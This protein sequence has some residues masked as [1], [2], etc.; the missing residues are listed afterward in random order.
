MAG[1]Y[2][3]NY[4]L[5]LGP[6]LALVLAI[7]GPAQALAN[8]PG[9]GTNGANVT[10][11]DNGTTVTIANGI[12][13][14][15]CNKSSGQITTLNYTFNNTGSL[16]TLNLL[17]GNPNGGKLYWENSNNQGLTFT[18]ALIADPANNGGNYAE[19]ILS[20]TTVA[21][22]LMEIHYSLSRGNTGFYVTPIFI[23]RSTD[24][25]FGMGECRDNIY[26][27]S[28]F[29]WMSVDAARNRLMEVSGGSAIGVNGAPVE[30]SLWTNG[31][32]AGQYEDKYK[33]G[34]DF[35]RQRAWGWSSVGTGGKNVGLWNVCGSVEYYNGGPMKRELMEHIG[36][37]ILNMINGGHYGSAGQD[38][39][40][41]AGEVWS[42][43]Y[44]PYLIY[45]N[46]ITNAI[47]ATNQA[48]QALYNDALAQAAAEQAA[49]PYSWFAN[50]NY[51]AATNRGTVTG[52]ISI[53]DTYDPNAS[54]ANLWVGVVQ[55][56][57]TTTATYDFQL[58]VKPYQFWVKTDM[59]GN[60]SIPDV[61]AGGNYTLYAFGAGAP[62]TYQSQA[63]TGGN[64]PNTVSIPASPFSVTVTVGTTNNLGTVTW[65]PARVA[66]T[67]FE[68]GYP[69]RTGAKFRHGEDWW[70]GDLGPSAAYPSPIW[71]KW[72]ELS[73]DYP[74]G[75]NYT[76]G[77]S[78][79]TTDWNFVQPVVT[80]DAGN[81]NGSSSTITF[82]LPTAPSG[83]ASF[84]LALSSD[85]QG[86]L[87]I[88]VNGGN[89]AG[90]TGYFPNYSSSSSGSDV[91]IRESDHGVFSDT[92]INF[93]ATL[94]H[95]GQNTIT[96]NMRK[97]G[98]F[99]NHAMYD[100][101]RLEVPNY[102]PPPPASSVAYPGN[103]CALVCWP[104]TPGATSYNIL[105]ST[106]TGTG[107]V[108]I[109]NGVVGPVCG[110][111]WNNATY[112]DAT[113]ANGTT[114]YYVVR[115]VNPV[116]SST[117]SPQSSATPSAALSTSA[118]AVP[119][120]LSIG[121]ATHQSVTLNWAAAA[122]A[123]FY[124]IYRS[125]L[126]NNGG[127]ASNILATLVL[128]NNVIG[129][130]YTDTSSTDGS[131]Y[132][133]S[134]T[135][136]SAGGT[137]AL[138]TAAIAKPLPNAPATAPGSLLATPSASTNISLDWSGVSGAVGY[139]I[140]RATSVNG[141]YL[142]LASITETTYTDYGV[143]TNSTYFYKITA[144]NAGGVSTAAITTTKPPTPTGLTAV[145]GNTKVVLKW[146]GSI[147]ATNYIIK[148]AL[149][150]GNEL[151]IANTTA[152]NYTDVSLT[153]GTTYY[154]VVAADGTDT[155]SVNS[156]EASATPSLPPP[157]VLNLPA[158]T[159]NG[160]RFTGTG[161]VANAS[162]YLL[163]TT[164]LSLPIANWPRLLTNQ[165]DGS[166]N[167][168]FTNALNPAWPQGF[169]LLQE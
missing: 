63:Q 54:A 97:G 1:N 80:D 99:A 140:Q 148:R 125:T 158:M 143:N 37:T 79:W 161:G 103:N 31:I 11:T 65:T 159:T 50:T 154:Y 96:I 109:T 26:A 46:N 163:G 160:F 19:I 146:N 8:P 112:L 128:A 122:G 95:A 164:N 88:Q 48:A 67:V 100:Y 119:T 38:G 21:N 92:R 72:L 53:S 52:K 36:T 108:S 132:S 7:F 45:C 144:M 2:A 68:I 141:G 39:T 51:A 129:T 42:K 147:G 17:S 94:L 110:S 22:V 117:N 138:S 82:N 18:Y 47:T 44:G 157:P 76:V 167:F 55:Q 142:L 107:Y 69:D 165:F 28:I 15:V 123:N 134:V 90:S 56:P 127:G 74:G 33:Y 124:T 23:H 93:S 87:I 139:V 81:Y 153:N 77:Q 34:A 156:I 14:I 43:V 27:G 151:A 102:I 5:L 73:F 40:W 135:A 150:S 13:S 16:Q 4:K 61:I 136:S 126:V 137:S 101:L 9:G 70:V 169:Y 29:N 78:R 168:N 41:A 105:R 86:P 75:L 98:Y 35:G 111:G 89:I 66:P 83:T 120:G 113:A 6:V 60:F 149:S 59:N 155:T 84:Y 64:T 58:W 25:A 62:G 20:S 114:Y 85:Y 118:P 166:G 121:G 71:S 3:L 57:V 91:T 145:A 10:L 152:T 130:T 104:V 133:Y 30:V 12:V 32:Y 162:F 106:T 116:G 49:W 24:G 131:I 115:S